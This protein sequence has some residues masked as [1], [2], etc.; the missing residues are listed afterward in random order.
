MGYFRTWAKV[1]FDPIEFQKQLP[2]VGYAKPAL[3][4]F[5]TIIMSNALIIL[6]VLLYALVMSYIGAK[7]PFSS[8]WL[9]IGAVGM[10]VVFVA[11][12]MAW[13]YV[14]A[15][16]TH[17]FVKMFGGQGSYQDTFIT[18]GYSYGAL[19]FLPVLGGLAAIYRH[20]LVGFGLYHRQNLST[21]KTIAVILIPLFLKYMIIIGLYVIFIIFIFAGLFS[22]ATALGGTM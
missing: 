20:I 3:F 16:I 9:V 15:G 7:P 11:F 6:F 4:A 14:R 21:G 2:K 13:L 1:L 10:Y 12:S 19:L 8:W 18:V 17:L 22:A 5:K